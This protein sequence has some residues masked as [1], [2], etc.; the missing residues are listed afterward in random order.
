[1]E[2]GIVVGGPSD[3]PSFGS[4]IGSHQKI[5]EFENIHQN[6]RMKAFIDIDINIERKLKFRKYDSRCLAHLI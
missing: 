1:M 2:I 5:T 6:Y 3:I 4:G